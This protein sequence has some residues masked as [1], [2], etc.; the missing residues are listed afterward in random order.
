M[1]PG[2]A[3]IRMA[4]AGAGGGGAPGVTVIGRVAMRTTPLIVVV[5]VLVVPTVTP[6]MLARYDESPA[7]YV[8]APTV[9]ALVPPV[10]VTFTV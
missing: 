10:T 2:S 9:T 1:S 8:M 6:V 5:T 7:L 3:V 4:V